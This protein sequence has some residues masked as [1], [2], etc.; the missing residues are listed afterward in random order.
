MEKATI[1]LAL[2][3]VISYVLGLALLVLGTGYSSALNA[4]AL[5]MFAVMGAGWILILYSEVTR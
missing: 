5:F 1:T 2:S 4:V 3:Q